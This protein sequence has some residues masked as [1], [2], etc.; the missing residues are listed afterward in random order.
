MSAFAQP[1]RWGACFLLLLFGSP[2]AGG[3]PASPA[4]YI[5]LQPDLLLGVPSPRDVVEALLALEP[6]K[7]L[8]ETAPVREFYDST[9]F[10]RFKKL[11]AY[12]E[13]EL[14]SP[15]P[16][17]LDRLAG[18]GAVFALK[19]ESPK[20]SVL[21]VIEGRD[22]SVVQKFFKLSSEIIDQEL[23]RQEAKE[24]LERATYR[25]T[26]TI[27]V[28]NEFHAAAV[29]KV[30]LI[31]NSKKTLQAAM[32]RVLSNE[33]DAAAVANMGQ[34]QKSLPPNPLAWGWLNL[35]TIR[36]TPQ[37]KEVFA[38]PRNEAAFTVTL[39]GWLDMARRS[40]FLCGGVYRD[41]RGFR[42][43]LQMPAGRQGMP[44]EITVHVPPSDEAGAL[45]LLEPNG[46]VMSTSYY[47]DLSKFWSERT[48]LFNAQQVKALE[49]FEQKS[50]PF[51]LGN[52]LGKLLAR[53]GTH[54]R[55]VVTNN[56][57]DYK[58]GSAKEAKLR[59]GYAL[60]IDGR[61][62]NFAK[63]VGSVL[64]G[65]AL[66]LGTQVKLQQVEEKHGST[67]L[68]G[69]RVPD[70]FLNRPENR[71][72]PLSY[73]T[74]PCFAAVGDQFVVCSTMELG[75][76]LIVLLEKQAVEK[77]K[78]AHPFSTQTRVYARGAAGLLRA[79]EEQLIGQAILNQAVNPAEAKEQM[80]KSVDW[81]SR[82]GQMRIEAQY[83]QHDFRLE[84]RYCPDA[85]ANQPA[86]VT[87]IH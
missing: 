43:T 69:Y 38:Q 85:S 72:N 40:P 39:G 30:I 4:R 42:A 58:G 17:L 6:L 12:F 57:D 32:G 81:V 51:L 86:A 14:G 28:G 53:A 82:L 87:K 16:E 26:P 75:R 44:E 27:Q 64:R 65:A 76:E 46:V 35:E 49:E 80:D 2:A 11:V 70:E 74:S 3:T 84:I 61:D 25:E 29:G 54:H 7:Q 78:A 55:F 23:G 73:I 47:L 33:S 24:K 77:S 41:E 20:A 9:N 5:P 83:G 67:T 60:V 37:G 56:S 8:P 36:K 48:K 45:P 59:L 31:S 68:V 66:L 10:L 15:W 34:A 18:A 63:A 19:Q 1:V 71:N 62:K 22:P 13:K 50:G 79:A 21:V 52:R